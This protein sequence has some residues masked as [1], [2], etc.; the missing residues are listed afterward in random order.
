MK[1]DTYKL[2]SNFIVPNSTVLNCT[3]TMKITC[4]ISNK[5]SWSEMIDCSRQSNIVQSRPAKMLQKISNFLK[6]SSNI[7]SN[8]NCLQYFT[9]TYFNY[10]ATYQ[11]GLDLLKPNRTRLNIF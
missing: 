2:L 3:L 7:F 6:F 8:F 5:I 4:T 10:F 9:C 11:T 1:I